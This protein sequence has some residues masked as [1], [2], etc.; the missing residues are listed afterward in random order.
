M[1]ITFDFPS[2]DYTGGVQ[3]E[4]TDSSLLGDFSVK[5]ILLRIAGNAAVNFFGVYVAPSNLTLAAAD[6]ARYE[7]YSNGAVAVAVDPAPDLNVT[8]TA[9]PFRLYDG[10]SI[11]VYYVG[12]Q[13]PTVATA[14]LFI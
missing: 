11:Y 9:I 12:D 3:Q 8:G 6:R 10:W 7:I 13:N 4:Y 1:N 2:D 5:R 14:D